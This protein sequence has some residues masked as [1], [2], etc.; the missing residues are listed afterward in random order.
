MEES[1]SQEPTDKS[2]PNSVDLSALKSFSFG[3]EWSQSSKSSDRGSSARSD[4]NDSRKSRPDR[5][6]GSRSAPSRDRRPTKRKFDG[7]SGGDGERS[8]SSRPHYEGGG[9]GQRGGGRQAP[10]P[11]Y[12]SPVFAVSFYPEDNS[13]A[14]IIKAMRSNHLTYELFE[15]SK[16]FL[17][18]SDRFIASI[19]CK[20]QGDEKAP[21]VFVS[22]PDG[23]PFPTE[24]DA[25]SHAVAHSIET[26]FTV[27]EV[28]VEAPTGNFPFVNR[29]SITKVLLGP[30]NYHKYEQALRNHHSTRLSHLPFEKVQSAVETVREEEAIN[31]WLESM[32]KASR[33]VSKL[34]EEGQ[35]PKIFNSIEEASFYLKTE[36]KAKVVK[37]VNYAR[38]SGV[39]LEK[40]KETEAYKAVNG[41][42]LRQRRFPLDTANSIRGRMRREK[43][44][45]YKKGAKG[46]TFVCATKRNFRVPGQVMAESLDRIMRFLDENAKIKQKEM[47]TV[48]EEWLKKD[49]PTEAFDEKKMLRDL[50]WLIADGYVS[51][52]S[53]DSLL[54]Q[55]VMTNAPS[56]DKKSAPAKADAATKEVKKEAPATAESAEAKPAVE[57]APTKEAATPAVE[58]E[59]PT[60]EVATPTPTIEAEAKPA[61]D[62]PVAE[63]NAEEAPAAES[64]DAPV[65]EVED[66]KAPA[67]EEE[68]KS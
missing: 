5:R 57:E 68:T 4:R 30:P 27:E 14:T 3:T 1:S 34:V 32:K 11:P 31:E 7:P 20:P 62:A 18:K 2:L 42:L 35:E 52:F 39:E 38:I 55:P 6:S 19:T 17:D 25:I 13:F 37:S 51:H 45:I 28:E 41:E 22:V 67:G 61:E 59:T 47:H 44:S 64:T 49:A 33:Y 63:A 24:E 36:H 10:Q 9:R 54:A 40:F 65:T 16:I 29:C 8:E 15:V 46:V 12:E 23:M 56:S 48:Y 21:K 66:K 58:T 43:F 50:H 53:D 26:F 60:E